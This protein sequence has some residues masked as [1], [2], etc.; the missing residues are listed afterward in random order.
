MILAPF[1]RLSRLL[2]LTY[3]YPTII[4]PFFGITNKICPPPNRKIPEKTRNFHLKKEARAYLS[5][6]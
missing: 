1:L 5:Q 4:Q 3:L 2:A 6:A